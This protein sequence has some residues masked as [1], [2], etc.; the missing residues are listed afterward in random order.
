MTSSTRSVAPAFA[1]LA[2]D[3]G[4]DGRDFGLL[5]NG[6]R[7]PWRG[8]DH[9]DIVRLPGGRDDYEPWLRL[10]AEAD[11]NMIRIGGTMAYE[12]PDFFRLCDEFG[13]LVWQDFMFSNFDYPKGD[14]ALNTHV[15]A[16]VAQF[17]SAT[18]LSPSL[19]V[20][21]GGSEIHQ[22]AAMFGLPERLW[23]S[24]I[25]EE[26]I[27]AVARSLRPDVPY[28]VNSP[29][30]GAMPF[31]SNEGVTHYYGVGAYM[32]PLDDTRRADVRFAAKAWLSRTTGQIRTLGGRR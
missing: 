24:P 32:R 25:V 7:M 19:A 2:I 18:R 3:R 9:A 13:L 15:E 14:N 22:Q 20:I 11:M 21:C 16:E 28:V 23:A 1:W 6:E 29:F 31:S 8:L 27:P 4:A 10:A 12:T 5:V 26:I 30:G 17:L